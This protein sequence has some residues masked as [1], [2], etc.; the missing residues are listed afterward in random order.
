M[1]KTKTPTKKKA[2]KAV[3][4]KEVRA[5]GAAL[6]RAGAAD[7]TRL[8]R[9]VASIT[10]LRVDEAKNW[11]ALWE[12]VAEVIDADGALWRARYGSVRAFLKAVMPG[13]SERTAK[14]KAMV[15]V[16]FSAADEVRHGVAFLEEAALY[17]KAAAGAQRP[18][19]AIDLDRLKVPVVTKDGDHRSK[20]ARDSS[21]EELRAARRKLEGGAKRVK[22]SPWEKAVRA[23]IGE[24][25]ELAGVKVSVRG[26]EVGLSGI[27]RGAVKKLGAALVKFRAPEE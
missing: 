3:G 19:R 6:A 16:S 1:A 23:A 8:D 14:R 9:V 18:P 13:E 20:R 4:A 7:R 10:A 22:A 21:V 24:Q 25:A 12:A 5:T 11:D 27:P 2:T 17:A 15:A 26:E